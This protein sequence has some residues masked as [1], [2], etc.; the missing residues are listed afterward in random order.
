MMMSRAIPAGFGWAQHSL[1]V[2]STPWCFVRE[3]DHHHHQSAE[4]TAQQHRFSVTMSK[5]KTLQ[6]LSGRSRIIQ[7][8]S[9]AREHRKKVLRLSLM[10]LHLIEDPEAWLRR[11]VLINNTFRALQHHQ[12]NVSSDGEL[13]TSQDKQPQHQP[14]PKQTCTDETFSDVLLPPQLEKQN[15]KQG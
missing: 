2:L 8:D 9:R 14:L 1:Q 10:K 5:L 11:S 3:P 15:Y 6:Q 12:H 13:A 7:R 4:Q